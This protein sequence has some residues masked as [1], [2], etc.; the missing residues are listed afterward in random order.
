M[1]G[2]SRR[3][4]VMS[5]VESPNG[6]VTL[7]VWGRDWESGNASELIATAAT[8][9]RRRAPARWLR[10]ARRPVQK[11]PRGCECSRIRVI[12]LWGAVKEL[13]L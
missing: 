1:A 2:V 6:A 8:P 7:G 13:S 9:A 5:C 12:G 10:P 3:E 11:A 4:Y